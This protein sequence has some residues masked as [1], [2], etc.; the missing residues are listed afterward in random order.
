MNEFDIKAADWDNNPMHWERS[1]AIV[2]GILKQLPLSKDMTALEYGAGTGITS[3]LLKDHMKEITMMDNSAEMV[4]V[5][6]EKIRAAETKNL[7]AIF[8]DLETKEWT[9]KKFDLLI[10]QMVLHHVD[11][12]DN[13]FRKFYNIIAPE[14][15]LAIADLYTENGSFHGEGFTGH[16]GFETEALSDSLKKHGFRNISSVKCFVINKKISETESGQFDVFLL[17]A[18]K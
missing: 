5:M 12:I 6:D 11:D 14:G 18:N 8:F 1:R 13:I 10:T 16:R 15:Y 3:F 4:R 2:N 17:T 7:K 9:G